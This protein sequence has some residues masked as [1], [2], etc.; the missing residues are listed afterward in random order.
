MTQHALEA[1]TTVPYR[2][3]QTHLNQ[4]RHDTHTVFVAGTMD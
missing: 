4:H 3:L 1:R 2:L